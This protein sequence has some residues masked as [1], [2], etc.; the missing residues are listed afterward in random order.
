MA[1]LKIATVRAQVAL[2]LITDFKN[3]SEF[4]PAEYHVAEVTTM[5]DQV[6]SWSNA[7]TTVR[8]AA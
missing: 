3:Y 2:S 7:L 8:T 6:V 4:A 1:E 5:L